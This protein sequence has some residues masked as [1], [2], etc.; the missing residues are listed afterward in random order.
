MTMSA[1]N[2]EGTVHQF[3]LSLAHDAARGHLDIEPVITAGTLDMLQ[4]VDSGKLDFAIVQGGYR[5]GSISQ[6]PA[7]R[8]LVGGTGPSTRQEEY[9]AAVL[10]D[11]RNLRGRTINL[12][13]SK[14]AV[15]YWLSQ[16]IL[17]FVGLGTGRLSGRWR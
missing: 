7:G 8:R 3:L 15:T 1:G 17:S 16:E 14:H 10:E 4:R 5:H 2:S 9:H 11:L 13:R 12:G 6:H